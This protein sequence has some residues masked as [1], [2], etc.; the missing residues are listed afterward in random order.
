MI[1]IIQTIIDQL[2]AIRAASIVK[3]SF[4]KEIGEMNLE[5]SLNLFLKKRYLQTG[6]D[7]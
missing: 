6:D 2:L 7:F 1:Q 5:E 3:L 4:K